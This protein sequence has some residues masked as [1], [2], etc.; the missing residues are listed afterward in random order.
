VGHSIEPVGSVRLRSLAT[1]LAAT[2]L[3]AAP[4]A[5]HAQDTA[6]TQVPDVRDQLK[7]LDEQVRELRSQVTTGRQG[8]LIKSSD[9]KF[10]LRIGGNVQAD[11]RFYH[12]DGTP[13]L[14]NTFLLRR[15]RP[16]LD[17]TVYELFEARVMPDFAEGRVQLFDAYVGARVLPGLQ[18]RA[19]KFKGPVSLERL[20]SQTDLVFIERAFPTQ[21]APNRELGLSVGGDLLG[22]KVRY[23]LGLFDGVVDG[24]STDGDLNDSKDGH[25]R[26]FVSPFTS[27][28]GGGLSGLG[29]G[30]AGTL[31][32]EHGSPTGPALASYRTEGQTVFFSYRSDGTALATAFADGRRTRLGAQAYYFVGPLGLMAEGIRSSQ[33]VNR[34][35]TLAALSAKAWQATGSFALTGDQASYTGLAPRKPVTGGGFGAVEL[36]ARVGQLE[37]DPE[38]FPTFADPTRSAQKATEWAVGVN[39]HF[40]RRIKLAANYIRTTFDGGA[41]TGDREAENAILTRFQVAF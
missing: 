8:F 18:F 12:S 32:E 16:I 37:L 1:A 35:G 4:A 9:G 15:V 6:A 21:I 28:A 14:T 22:G 23:D 27:A 2:I 29:F 41:A 19:G 25:A 38:V 3:S 17:A 26:I 39:W 20:Q 36:V 5:A 13:A 10:Q 40:E 7:T 33:I 34:A 30:V 31:G 11:G 24:S